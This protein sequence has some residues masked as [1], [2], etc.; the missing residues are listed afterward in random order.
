[1]PSD[2]L[3]F[4][5][6]LPPQIAAGLPDGEEIFAIGDLHGCSTP[7]R[8]ALAAI[9][10]EPR[11]APV[12]RLVLL[13]DLIDRG[14][15][16]PG[17]LDLAGDAAALARADE[18]IALMGNHEIMLKQM[19]DASLPEAVREAAG[20]VWIRNGGAHVLDQLDLLRSRPLTTARIVEALGERRM[21]FLNALRTSWRTGDVV[22]VHAG[23]PVV[24]PYEKAMQA[25]WAEPLDTLREDLHWSWIREP[26]LDRHAQGVNKRLFV[27]HGHTRPV[28]DRRHTMEERVAMGRLNLDFG[29]YESGQIGVARLVG[30]RIDVAR[31]RPS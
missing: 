13:G 20:E 22:F 19:L 6:T 12:R 27:V 9:A 26:F 21:G 5:F 15:D 11:Q 10:A 7:F 31:Y 17:A 29:S 18:A 25:T 30:R 14:P 28:L 16:S 23:L 24:L 3:S 8:A 4:K 2:F 1:M